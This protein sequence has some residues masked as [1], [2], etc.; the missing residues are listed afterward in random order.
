[1]P[2]R[3]VALTDHQASLVAQLVTSGRYQN[4]SE[5]L[6][7]GSRFVERRESGDEMCLVALREAALFGIADIEAGAFRTFDSADALGQRLAALTSEVTTRSGG[8]SLGYSPDRSGEADYRPILHWT[9]VELRSGAS[10]ELCRHPLRCAES[11]KHWPC[12][13]WCQGTHRDRRSYPDASR[14]PRRP[15]MPALRGVTSG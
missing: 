13:P 5:V 4:A 14:G 9:L 15:K 7:K 2:T 1:M 11:I 3:N 8:R 6:R 12:N 10:A